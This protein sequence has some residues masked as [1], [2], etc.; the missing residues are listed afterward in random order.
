MARDLPPQAPP[1]S[2]P[3]PVG[4]P[5]IT[6]GPT[7]DQ[8]LLYRLI[9]HD[10]SLISQ[11]DEYQHEINP[12]FRAWLASTLESGL[13]AKMT[14][15]LPEAEAM[16]EALEKAAAGEPVQLQQ[17]WNV[18]GQRGG[19][20]LRMKFEETLLGGAINRPGY[21]ERWRT[22]FV[23][24]GAKTQLERTDAVAHTPVSYKLAQSDLPTPRP[25]FFRSESEHQRYLAGMV[26]SFTHRFIEL[27]VGPKRPGDH[28]LILNIVTVYKE[29]DQG[30][31][32][33]RFCINAR[34][35]R[36]PVREEMQARHYGTGSQELNE[37][38]S[39]RDL[40]MC[41]DLPSG[42]MQCRQTRESSNRELSLIT[43]TDLAA[44]YATL[45]K[46]LPQGLRKHWHRGQLCHVV[47]PRVVQF[48][49]P[50]AME[51]FRQRQGLVLAELRG[52]GMRL[53]SQVDDVCILCK[54]GVAETLI[55]AAIYLSTMAFYG[56]IVHLS[57]EKQPEWPSGTVVF[58]GSMVCFALNTRYSPPAKDERHRNQLTE[59]LQRFD[60][61]KP[62]TMQEM[63]STVCQQQ[64]HVRS[65]WPTRLLLSR[66]RAHVSR[67]QIRLN[68]LH[69]DGNIWGQRV[70]PFPADAASDL[71]TLALPRLAGEATRPSGPPVAT[72]T[73]DASCFAVGARYQLQDP[74][75]KPSR[76]E[77]HKWALTSK[78]RALTHTVQE[79]L[80]VAAAGLAMIKR[81]D[82]QAPPNEHRPLG[83]ESDNKASVSAINKPSSTLSMSERTREVLWTA[84][85]LRL[86]CRAFYLPK[87][88]MDR[89]SCDLDGRKLSH[90]QMWGLELKLFLRAMTMLGVSWD[91]STAFDLAACRSTTKAKRFYSRYDQPGSAGVDTFMQR[92]DVRGVRYLYL[93]EAV[94]AQGLQ[95]LMQEPQQVVIVVPLR[96]NAPSWW[97]LLQSMLGRYV[98]IPPSPT[99]H[100]PPEGRNP[101]G[102]TI[103]EPGRAPPCPLIMGISYDAGSDLDW[104][105]PLKTG[106]SPHRSSRITPTKLGTIDLAQFGP[107]PPSSLVL[108]RDAPRRIGTGSC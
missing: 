8:A 79:N 30:L 76:I 108:S 44:V 51:L 70:R 36:E 92:W 78:E 81:F 58:D 40:G 23:S 22:A 64:S 96:H 50:R 83:F 13:R 93:P 32:K 97:P 38:M 25:P 18:P 14:A 68:Q 35:S 43:A 88:L 67:E 19:R 54:H 105:R 28:E 75:G 84:R 53:A 2:G 52:N 85:E 61:N 89:T 29:S 103:G 46:A 77:R 45:G 6:G 80:S 21:T 17:W 63:L 11:L 7:I 73:A 26:K 31:S 71:R 1:T 95:R 3:Y 9:Q 60:G 82:L 91:Y 100:F 20:S 27:A 107:A 99:S 87:L 34:P 37:I 16:L 106:S 57:G 24:A 62:V 5:I 15:Q 48:G 10:G 66:V 49:N 59:M 104:D 55:S 56:Y 94:V 42:Y 101:Q 47:R 98:V 69:P 74:A 41:F 33:P 39:R 4:Q 86:L 12:A 65:H 102:E 72:V 90:G